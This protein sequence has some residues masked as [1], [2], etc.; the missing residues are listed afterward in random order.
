M[1]DRIPSLQ[2][3]AIPRTPIPSISDLQMGQSVIEIDRDEVVSLLRDSGAEPGRLLS[4]VA[5]AEWLARLAPGLAVELESSLR[6]RLADGRR[7]ADR[8]R[9]LSV[10]VQAQ[11]AHRAV[12]RLLDSGARPSGPEL[13][14]SLRK[15]AAA[16]EAP[17]AGENS[18]A[19]E[20]AETICATLAPADLE[21][22][23]AALEA[24]LAD[25]RLP[26]WTRLHSYLALA[27]LWDQVTRADKAL[28][29]ALADPGEDP[30]LRTEA[31][32]LLAP[33]MALPVHQL[34][35]RGLLPRPILPR[36]E[37][38]FHNVP[39]FDRDTE[40]EWTL[41]PDAV[42]LGH[43]VFPEDLLAV[44]REPDANPS[45]ACSAAALAAVVARRLPSYV[46]Q[47]ARALRTAMGCDAE[48]RAGW[49]GRERTFRLAELCSMTLRELGLPEVEAEGS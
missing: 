45:R 38:L 49:A 40:G 25:R 32:S 17:G 26:A 5:L 47:F 9:N 30:V 46:E 36:A 20:L 3:N 4:A 37:T 27:R 35:E 28:F 7:Y 43:L 29:A 44:L 8:S 42:K 1:P 34:Q 12:W 23:A 14:A 21:L 48:F 15:T 19:A 18:R 13:L 16:Q 22:T 2:G 10:G 6:A 11:Y 24:D 31:H 33:R 39:L 41:T